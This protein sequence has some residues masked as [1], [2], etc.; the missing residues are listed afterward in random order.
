M[1]LTVFSQK[2]KLAFVFTCADQQADGRVRVPRATC[3]QLP[4]LVTR[5]RP[6]DPAGGLL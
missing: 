5:G 3:R 2:A 6:L 4:G 1:Q